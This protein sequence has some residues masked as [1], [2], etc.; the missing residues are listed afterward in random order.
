[1]QDAQVQELSKDFAYENRQAITAK[2]AAFQKNVC[3]KLLKNK[4]NAEVFRLFVINQFPPGNCI[5]PPP[6][7]LH[8]IFEAI[9]KHGLWDFLHYSPLVRIIQTFAA[10]DTE[11]KDWVKT[12]KK[13][14]R[15]YTLTTTVEKYIEADLCVSG[16]P[17]AN[18]PPAKRAKYDPCYCTP[19]EWKTECIDHSLQYFTEVWELFSSRYLM[20]DS[21]PTALLDRVRKGCFVVTWLIPSTLTELLIERVLNINTDFL[22]QHYIVKVTV[23]DVCIYEE[24]TDESTTVSSQLDFAMILFV[25]CVNPHPQI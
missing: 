3:G 9:T 18:S 8:E 10:D 11:M 15:S 13:D 1:M 7:C 21:P 16:P 6:A 12:Y 14:L 19:V 4:V 22:Q 25:N 2:F 23:G 20:P 5:P 24:V 17:N